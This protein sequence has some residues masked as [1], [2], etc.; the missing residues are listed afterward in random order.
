LLQILLI[1]ITSVLSKFYPAAAVHISTIA[2]AIQSFIAFYATNCFLRMKLIRE[3][4]EEIDL[5]ASNS[6]EEAFLRFLSGSKRG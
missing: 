6:E 2:I 1:A 5:I 4:Y 3:G